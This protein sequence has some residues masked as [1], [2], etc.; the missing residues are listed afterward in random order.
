MP[1]SSRRLTVALPVALTLLGCEDTALR[2]LEQRAG[3]EL[4]EVT[5]IQGNRERFAEEDAKLRGRLAELLPWLEAA[6]RPE[7]MLAALRE[8]DG[9]EVRADP[10]GEARVLV[11]T[12]PDPGQPLSLVERLLRIGRPVALSALRCD[13]GGCTGTLTPPQWPT[14]RARG[15]PPGL[16]DLPPRPWWPPEAGRWERVRD[17]LTTLE[18]AR[19]ALGPLAG[20]K[21][22]QEE[23]QA[24]HAAVDA[25]WSSSE[26]VADAA[27]DAL[28]AG[29]AKAEVTAFDHPDGRSVRVVAP[30][31]GP[32]L[33]EALGRRGRLT[34]SGQAFLVTVEHL[35]AALARQRKERP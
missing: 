9:A 17:E 5:A 10:L 4:V 28:A 3:A 33:L 6:A 24:L 25:A 35:G 18:S 34:M 26:L 19:A 12:P 15:T 13:A 7:G 22:R 29:A 31:A 30:G 1:A 14:R 16:A 20:I 2:K 27:R 11:R 8:L 32:A 23:L 21:R